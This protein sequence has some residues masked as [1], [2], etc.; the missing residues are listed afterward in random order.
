MGMRAAA[1]LANDPENVLG[2]ADLRR[3]IQS[4]QS[5]G[6]KRDPKS[7]KVGCRFLLRHGHA[8]LIYRIKCCTNT[9][10]CPRCRTLLYNRL[11]TL[12][13]DHRLSRKEL[14]EAVG[15]NFQTIGYLE[16]GEYNPSIE[17]ALRLGEHF[18]LPVEMIFS[19]QPFSPIGQELLRA[20][21]GQALKEQG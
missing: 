2:L 14:A 3:G 1:S 18:K 10:L 19:R 5:A 21:I 12:R 8:C 13:A 17:L 6:E 4:P 7:V 15:V 20:E 16:R 11:A 9:S